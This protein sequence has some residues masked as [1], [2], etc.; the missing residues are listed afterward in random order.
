M[1]KIFELIKQ[2]KTQILAIII[3]LLLIPI[4]K[5][6]IDKINKNYKVEVINKEKYFVLLSNN[7]IGVIDTTGKI[8][9]NPEYYE[10]HIPNPSKPIFVCYYDY[11]AETGECKTKV[12]NEQ[13]TELFTTY[14]N[15]DTIHLNG[16]ETSMPYEKNLLKYEKDNKYGLI[17]LKGEKIID[18]IY[19]EIEGLNYKEGELLVKKDNKY[20]VINNKGVELIKTKY[21]YISGDEYYTPNK[22][23]KLSGYIIGEKTS[24]GYRY[25]Y[26]NNEQKTLL[27]PEY[28]EIIRI[29][30]IEKEDT[31]KNVFIIARKNGQCGLIR[32]KK[33]VID[34]KY[35]E[36]NYSG[37]ENLFILSR[38][39]KLGV[40]NTKGKKILSNQYE[41]INITENYIYTKNGEE[42]KYFNLK[43]EEINKDSIKQEKE[44]E[45]EETN[46]NIANIVKP[47]LIP[48][49]KDGKWGFVD[50][51]LQL[52]V[53]YIY[54]EATQVNQYGF[55]GIKKDG[56]WGCIDEKGNVIQEPIYNLKDNDDIDFIGK[57]YKVVYNY[58]NIF[59]TDDIDMINDQN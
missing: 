43:G 5:I 56:K 28:S 3:I 53:D 37:V 7:K 45:E 25:G 17:N 1:K 39:T 40:Y 10:V 13:G 31:D 50:K 19:D 16:I 8:I 32:N 9:V 22:S 11:N 30:N 48:Q 15:I 2:Y 18:A 41:D 42:E 6:T 54:D 12:I 52:K 55:A 27:K 29:G 46:N 24:D 4:M 49:E 23:Y 34:F 59:Y 14:N 20:G 47:T 51:N 35:Q 21:D 58:Q 38:S 33:V 36:I 26:M 44:I 57:Y